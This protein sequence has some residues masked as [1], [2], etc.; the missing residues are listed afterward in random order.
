M[1]PLPSENTVADPPEPLWY[2]IEIERCPSCLD[3]HVAGEGCARGC[4]PHRGRRRVVG[5]GPSAGLADS[6]YLVDSL[7]ALERGLIRGLG[8]A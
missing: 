7:D 8:V 1:N 5:V 3:A 4:V 2:G 6:A